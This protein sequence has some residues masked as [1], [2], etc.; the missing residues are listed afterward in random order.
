MM[1]LDWSPWRPLSTCWADRDLASPGLYRVR[2]ADAGDVAYVGETGGPLRERLG[3]LRGILRDEMPYRDPHTA[4]PALWAQRQ[5]TNDSYEASTCPVGGDYRL[6]KGLEAVAIALYRQEHQRS[7]T[8]NFGRMPL[9]Y[10][11]SSANNSR[12][13]RA[14]KR[15]R[16]GPCDSPEQSHLPSL[17]PAGGLAGDAD[18]LSWCGHHWSEWVPLADG[19]VLVPVGAEGLYRIRGADGML[20]YVGEGKIRSRLKTHR[21]K[22]RKASER[23]HM[24]F[25]NAGP[26]EASWVACS[27]WEPH[28][29]EELE[30][31]LIAAFTLTTGASPAA[32]FLG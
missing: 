17:A 12:L 6:R 3:L 10:R 26:L 4:G 18:S 32:Q 22:A 25:A 20:L 21:A 28:Q 29:R 27:T 13:V 19:I 7:P 15:F 9:G 30:T 11:M 5:L 8:F 14:G 24:V 16:G 31:D 23:Q 1:V 2:R